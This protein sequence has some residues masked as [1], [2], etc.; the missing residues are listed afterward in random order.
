MPGAG[1]H[2]HRLF[3]GRG[4]IPDHHSPVTF[5]G[6]EHQ[7]GE[8]TQS[9][10]HNAGERRSGGDVRGG[11]GGLLERV[12]DH[13]GNGG[14]GGIFRGGLLEE[15]ESRN[16]ARRRDCY[17]RRAFSLLFLPA[18]LLTTSDGSTAR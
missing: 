4:G 8:R 14:C 15:D 9:A 11:R 12:P 18:L 10:L 5:R 16:I 1:G 2:L 3:R 13:D 7:R 17:R 6:E